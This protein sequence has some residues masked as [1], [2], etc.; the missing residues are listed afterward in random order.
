MMP[1]EHYGFELALWMAGTAALVVA[2]A[3]VG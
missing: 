2:V 3:L 1:P